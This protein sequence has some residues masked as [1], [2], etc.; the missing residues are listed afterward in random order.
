MPRLPYLPADLAEPKEVVDAIRAR[1]GGQLGE[2]DRI[3]LHCP[4]VAQGWN[5][6]MGAVRRDMTVSAKLRELA[7]C[8]VAMLNKAEYEWFHHAPLLQEAGATDAQLA[9]LREPIGA[10]TRPD[11]F[12]A[13]ERATIALSIEM[14]RQVEV[15]DS[16]F[17]A[18]RAVLPNDRQVFE[19][20]MTVAAYNM[21]S[22]ILVATGV[23]PEA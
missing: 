13:A 2:L 7:M 8:V 18:V 21:V 22:R 16:T 4:P 6:M 9:A 19:L 5:T 12:D 15:S 14:T 23:Q 1:R 3:L 20:I 11:L 17:A 10:L